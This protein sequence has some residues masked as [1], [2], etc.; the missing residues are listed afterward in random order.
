MQASLHQFQ[1]WDQTILIFNSSSTTNP[2][3]VVVCSI[4]GVCY[5]ALSNLFTLSN[6]QVADLDGRVAGLDK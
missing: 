2:D 3:I 1:S 6:H 4:I 5:R